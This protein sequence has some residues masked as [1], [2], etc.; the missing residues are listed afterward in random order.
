MTSGAP[1]RRTSISLRPIFTSNTLTMSAS[2]SSVTAI[3][4]S[5]P[6]RVP[7][8]PMSSWLSASTT[9][10]DSLPLA[11]TETGPFHRILPPYMDFSIKLSPMILAH[12]GTDSITAVRLNQGDPPKE[13]KLGNYTLTLTYT[14]R[15]THIAPQP[16]GRLLASPQP[17]AMAP[18]PRAAA[19]SGC[20]PH[21]D[22]SGRVLLCWWRHA[23]RLHPQHSRAT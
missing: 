6:K 16:K 22:R 5:F 21:R 4:F 19:R 23:H 15:N 2:G 17:S 14:G 12:Q 9:P 1:A 7:I 10:S 3:R 13:I 18:A 8:P 11:L 20:H